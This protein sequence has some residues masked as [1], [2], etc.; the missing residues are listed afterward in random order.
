MD[1]E[2]VYWGRCEGKPDT[3]YDMHTSGVIQHKKSIAKD[4]NQYID[5]CLEKIPEGFE[6]LCSE[7]ETAYKCKFRLRTEK[8]ISYKKQATV[9]T[10]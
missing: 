1:K 5:L 3:F 4:L 10:K 7:T 2:I 6:I 9:L 8:G